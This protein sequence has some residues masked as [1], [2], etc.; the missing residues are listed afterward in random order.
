MQMKLEELTQPGSENAADYFRERDKKYGTSDLMVPAI[1]QLQTDDDALTPTSTTCGEHM[2]CLQI[3]PRISPMAQGTS[4][5]GSS[6]KTLGSVKP[7]SN[8]SISGLEPATERDT[9]HMLK[10]KPDEAVS[11]YPCICPSANHYIDLGFGR[12]H[13]DGSFV[14]GGI[15]KQTVIFD[16]ISL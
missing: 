1:V 2:K 13:V 3:I 10:G 6:Q 12:R 7:Q 16:I 8:T 5:P 11:F 9:S 14:C 15:D 4:R